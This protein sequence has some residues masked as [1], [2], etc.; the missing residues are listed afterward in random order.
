MN[1]LYWWKRPR[2]KRIKKEYLWPLGSDLV[3]L[4]PE[5]W[6]RIRELEVTAGILPLIEV[7]SWKHK[8]NPSLSQRSWKTALLT[9]WALTRFQCSSFPIASG[10]QKE[11]SRGKSTQGSPSASVVGPGRP[12][13]PTAPICH[14]GEGHLVG[15]L[16]WGGLSNESDF[17]IWRMGTGAEGLRF[18]GQARGFVTQSYMFLEIPLVSFPIFCLQWW[19]LAEAAEFDSVSWQRPLTGILIFLVWAREVGGSKW[20]V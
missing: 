13:V 8:K 4:M 6:S 12:G 11:V 15:P 2:L 3:G 9:G 18:S 1:S 14:G 16:P 19:M 10:N 17:P 5:A 20:K 7:F